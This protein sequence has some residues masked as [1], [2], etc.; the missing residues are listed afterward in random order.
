MQFDLKATYT[1]RSTMW[2]T[3][4]NTF[5]YP[6]ALLVAVLLASIF[7]AALSVVVLKS[8]YRTAYIQ[9]EHL[10][11]QGDQ[12]HTEWMKLL[13]EEGT[14]ASNSRIENIATKDMNMVLPKGMDT[15]I[16]VVHAQS[17]EKNEASFE[18]KPL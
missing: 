10:I 4:R 7:I 12:L 11:Q 17:P 14:W 1:D 5:C 3:L 13:L 18:H 9:H 6:F 2:L 15:H 8:N 16:I